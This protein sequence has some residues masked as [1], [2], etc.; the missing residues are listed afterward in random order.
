MKKNTPEGGNP[1]C[2]PTSPCEYVQLP[3]GPTCQNGVT[4]DCPN[5]PLLE[6]KLSDFHDQALADATQKINGILA[7]N[8]ADPEGRKASF[9]VAKRGLLLAWVRHGASY[10]PK[11]VIPKDD[12]AALFKSL[13][14]KLKPAAK[15]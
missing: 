4:N 1:N 5:A 14:L 9:L 11:D 13:G 8:P 7:A 6:A 3:N 12:E 15:K 2:S 10:D